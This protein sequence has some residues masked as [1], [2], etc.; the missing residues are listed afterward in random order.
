MEIELSE[1]ATGKVIYKNVYPHNFEVNNDI[2]ENIREIRSDHYSIKINE[3]WF[4]GIHISINE[5][6]TLKVVDFVFKASDEN[7]GL[8]YCMEGNMNY[9]SDQK[10]KKIFSIGARQQNITAGKLS[11]VSFDVTG[12]AKYIY[13]QLTKSYYQRVANT[14][15]TD[16]NFLDDTIIQPEIEFLLLS[17]IN[18]QYKG[19]AS[20][21]FIESKI[22]EL[23][24]FYLDQKSRQVTFS[25]K[26]DDVEKILLAKHLIESDLQ[27]PYS[28]LELSRKAGINDY[29]LKKG[30]KEITG[31]T[32]FG[33]LYKIRMEQAYYYLAKQKKSVNEVS[34]LVGYKNPQHFIVAFKKLY[35]ILPG[36]LNKS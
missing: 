11:H 21:L 13:I 9:Y 31:Y 22:F 32:V 2:D 10:I 34:F 20:R 15:Y 33:Y 7:V 19:R 3:K 12:K 26:K 8:L 29:K 6:E 27:K 23:I 25:L 35:K 18:S 24:I 16:E 4:E 1:Y 14:S 17:L 5:I 36:S 28:L 30:F